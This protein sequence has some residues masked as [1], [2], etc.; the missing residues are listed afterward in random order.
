MFVGVPRSMEATIFNKDKGQIANY[1]I[2][3]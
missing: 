3:L 2:N 1:S